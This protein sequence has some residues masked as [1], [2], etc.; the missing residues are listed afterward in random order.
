MG[1]ASIRRAL[2]TTGTL[3]SRPAA[4]LVVPAY[5]IG[6]YFFQP[7]TFDWNAVATLSVWLMT[8]FI[9][10]AGYRDTQAVHAKLDELLHAQGAARNEITRM[11]EEEP[12][13]RAPPDR[14]ALE[15]LT[16]QELKCLPPAWPMD[17]WV[18]VVSTSASTCNA[19]SRTGRHGRRRG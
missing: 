18:K 7:A 1:K 6:W 12:E 17:R 2:T 13:H 15:R 4:F 14:R 3:A 16:G 8:L 9:Q 19:C 11:D 5:G 10:R